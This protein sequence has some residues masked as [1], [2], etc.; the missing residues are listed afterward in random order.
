MLK[1]DN[2]L[3]K[4]AIQNFSI[5]VTIAILEK[6]KTLC[7]HL[8]CVFLWTDFDITSHKYIHFIMCLFHISE[9][10]NF[11]ITGFK[12]LTMTTKASLIKLSLSF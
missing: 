10:F 6:K 8:S 11:H 2:I 9:L 7:H 12:D 3:D 1:R 5:K 4:F